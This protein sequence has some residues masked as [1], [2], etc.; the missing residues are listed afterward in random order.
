MGGGGAPSAH[1]PHR[2]WQVAARGL[3]AARRASGRMFWCHDAVD[4]GGGEAEPK[5]VKGHR[6]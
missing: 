4:E 2:P 6:M 3:A 5:V 1:L